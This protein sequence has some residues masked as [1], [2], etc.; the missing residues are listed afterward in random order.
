MLIS[1]NKLFI[2][3][4]LKYNMRGAVIFSIILLFV[5]LS[6]CASETGMAN[7]ASVYCEEQGYTSKIREYPNG[8]QMGICVKGEKICEEWAY[9][10]GECEL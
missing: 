9:Y 6:G 10:R 7:P 2:R 1:N 5:L 8:S 4:A 3:A